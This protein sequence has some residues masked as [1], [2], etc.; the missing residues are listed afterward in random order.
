MRGSADW[1]KLFASQTKPKTPQ[2]LDKLR[3]DRTI[4]CK[5]PAWGAEVEKPFGGFRAYEISRVIETV[6]EIR[7]EP[8]VQFGEIE[9]RISPKS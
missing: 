6:I 1:H 5:N 9:V 4:V 7:S 8:L 3:K 2:V